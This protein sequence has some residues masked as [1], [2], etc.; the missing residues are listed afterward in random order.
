MF[1]ARTGLGALLCFGAALF[2]AAPA[3]AQAK[4]AESQPSA[5][6]CLACHGDRDLKRDPPVPGRS[7]SLFADEAVLKGSVHARLECVACH[8][9]AT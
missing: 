6:D 5:Q 3:G 7:E 4:P 8:R 1:T 2:P 9:T